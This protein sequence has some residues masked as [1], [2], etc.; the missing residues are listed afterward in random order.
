MFAGNKILVGNY[1]AELRVW[2]AGRPFCDNYYTA[3]FVPYSKI[4][5]E[6]AIICKGHLIKASSLGSCYIP[7][8]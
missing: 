2:P 4:H 5:S 8:C 7:I 6:A 1:V 3:L